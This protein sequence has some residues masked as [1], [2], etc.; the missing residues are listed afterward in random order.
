LAQSP[1]RPGEG[2]TSEALAASFIYGSCVS[3]KEG[4]MHLGDIKGLL[5]RIQAIMQAIHPKNQKSYMYEN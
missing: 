3:V 1:V 4:G 5:Q 2:R